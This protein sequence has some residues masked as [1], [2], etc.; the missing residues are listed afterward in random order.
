MGREAEVDG[1]NGNRLVIV[2][3]KKIVRLE[4]QGYSCGIS[5]AIGS[6]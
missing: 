3:F 5:K 1:G 4:N 2:T 6:Q